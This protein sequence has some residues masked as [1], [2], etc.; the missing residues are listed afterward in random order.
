MASMTGIILLDIN[1]CIPIDYR[2]II[3]VLLFGLYDIRPRMLGF[4][5]SFAVQYL[6]HLCLIFVEFEYNA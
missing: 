3:N 4:G 1:L 6:P 2:N 5:P